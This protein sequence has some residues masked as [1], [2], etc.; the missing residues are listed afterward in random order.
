MWC[1]NLCQLSYGAKAKHRRSIIMITLNPWPIA[2]MLHHNE[3]S[4][5]SAI[6]EC[7]SYSL[8]QL[9]NTIIC[10]FISVYKIKINILLVF[11]L[12]LI[13]DGMIYSK[14]PTDYNYIL[15]KNRILHYLDIEKN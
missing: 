9:M 4:I 6:I 15:S 8:L 12:G 3:I 7:C 1:L 14:S 2:L 10:L 13:S 5:I 11:E